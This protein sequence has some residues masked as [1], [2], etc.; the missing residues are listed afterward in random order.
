MPQ[1]FRH[2]LKIKCEQKCVQWWKTWRNILIDCNYELEL[3][4]NKF[5]Q[6]A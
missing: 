1:F 6:Q 2:E 4:K 5:S 3:K